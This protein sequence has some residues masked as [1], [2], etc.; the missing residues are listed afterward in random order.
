VV[1]ELT[2]HHSAVV[3][4]LVFSP[5]GRFL[6]S[7]GLDRQVMI[8]DVSTRARWAILTG[9]DDIVTS[10][11][12]SPDGKTLASAGGDHVVVLWTLDPEEARERLRRAAS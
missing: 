2:G 11:D 6:A 10:L 9:H 12:F 3:S 1:A 7:G 8:W 4:T 5:D